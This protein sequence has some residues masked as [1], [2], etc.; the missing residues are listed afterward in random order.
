MPDQ[1]AITRLN[2]ALEGRYRIERQLG[3]GGMATVY[4]ARDERH[5]RNVALKVLKPELAA[6]VGAE[7]FLAEIETT[8][9][10]QHPHI[11]PLF[12]SGEADSFL[13]YVMPYV[14]GESL[15]DRLDREHQLPV[16]QAVEIGKNVAEALDYAHRQGIIHRDIKPANV[17]LQDGKPVVSD[18]GIALALGTAGGGRLTETGLSLGTPHYMSPEQATGDARVGSATDIYALGCV[19][20]EMLV[21]EPPYTG[22]TPQ[23]IL[24]KIVTGEADPVTVHRRS[25]PANVDGAIR[26][27]LEKVPADRFASA[28]ELAS[29]L[30]DPG[31]RHGTHF[32]GS[33]PTEARPWKRATAAVGALS[34]ALAVSL[35]MSLGRPAPV[36]TPIQFSISLP[37]EFRLAA[38]TC[39]APLQVLSPD[40]EWLV[41]V[42]GQGDDYM[43]YKRDIRR[44]E[45]E[46]M[47]GT[48][49]ASS[50]FFSSDGR[51]VGFYSDGAIRKVP[52]VGG[53]PVTI[54]QTG[55]ITG[56]SWG[57]NDLIVFVDQ[58]DR[59]L[60]T[61]PGSGGTPEAVELAGEDVRGF[62]TPWMLPGGEAALATLTG[63]G[64]ADFRIALVDLA[65]GEVDVLGA[66]TRV[67]FASD[68]LVYSTSAG[69]L[70]AQPFDPTSRETTGSLVTI[71]DG[72]HIDAWGIGQFAVSEQGALVYQSESGEAAAGDSI[73]ILGPDSAE[74][75]PIPEG[76]R[77]YGVT[78]APTDGRRLAFRMDGGGGVG[79]RIESDHIY[80]YDRD[81]GL[82]DQ[83]TDEGNRNML[84]VWSP[85]AT[86]IAFMSHR[87]GDTGKLYVSDGRGPAELVMK[88][89]YSAGPLSWS[90]DGR[91]IAFWARQGASRD[92]G[93]IALGESS[94]EWILRTPADEGMI[95]FSPDGRWIAYTSDR[96]GQSEVYVEPTD[97]SGQRVLVSNGG[98][99]PRWAPDRNAIYYV[100]T[101]QPPHLVATSYSVVDGSLRPGERQELMEVDEVLGSLNAHWDVSPDG[102]EFAFIRQVGDPTRR[103][104]HWIV[105]WPEMVRELTQ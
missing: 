71:L 91:R 13:F 63:G 2:A 5:N 44:L 68:H 57:D 14:E 38:S 79:G 59:Q 33:H 1:D 8:A 4:L 48:Q 56:A 40:G 82:I 15:R 52:L 55:L 60:F 29:A 46:P 10:L 62:R 19:L 64:T 85:D 77:V 102:R 87:D 103:G 53:A 17:L 18:F 11:L 95:Q 42:M 27:A 25:T 6:V 80:V 101:A 65:T 89:E 7:R 69:G 16:A 67:T 98:T 26:R 39:C 34:V 81:T 47:A 70:V 93:T 100:T 28:G 21:G 12:D 9:N 97:G 24:G 45:V 90:P 58:T 36:R 83:F 20:Y 23:A 105:N 37:S 104:V 3:E 30:T 66:G 31:F 43:L 32:G 74:V 35:A 49:D 76:S 92:I 94:P 61:V 84:A 99:R 75:V 54:A 96:S 73:V 22:S 88:S 78:F 51:W 86:R 50:P 72:L 41:F